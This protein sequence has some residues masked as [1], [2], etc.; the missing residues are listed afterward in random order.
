M[1]WNLLRSPNVPSLY[2][3]LDATPQRLLRLAEI[4]GW[5]PLTPPDGLP[6][7]MTFQAIAWD[8]RDIRGGELFVALRGEKV[9][10]HSYLQQAWEQGARAALVEERQHGCGI[11]QLL[12][13]DTRRALSVLSDRAWGQPSLH[14]ACIAITGTKG[15]TST[16]YFLQ[17]LLEQGDHRAAVLGTL[18]WSF[19][20]Q[21]T[22]LPL[23]TPE[24]PHLQHRF[25]AT[26]Q[27]GGTHAIFEASAHGIHFQRTRDIRLA[28]ALFTNLGHDHLDFFP[29]FEAYGATKDRLFTEQLIESPEGL[30]VLNTDDPHIAALAQVLPAWRV[31]ACGAQVPEG[32]QGR[33]LEVRR[34]GLLLQIGFP[35]G[36]GFDVVVPLAGRFFATN[37]LLA[38]ATAWSCGVPAP[39]IAQGLATMPP[40]PGRH[41]AVSTS[42]D[43]CQVIVDYAHTPESVSAIL[44]AAGRD[45]ERPLTVVIGCGGDRD[46][47]KRPQMG[48]LALDGADRVVI[49][50]DNPRSEDPLAII[51]Q[52]LEGIPEGAAN[53]LVTV[54]PDR[55]VAIARAIA[56]A[57][58]HGRVYILGKGHETYQ[59]FRDGKIDFDDCQHA[60]RALDARLAA[61]TEAVS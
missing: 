40:V 6:S 21:T 60:R 15:K 31:L 59:I 50:S 45:P 11:P 46:P 43:D 19:G 13:P 37:L 3:T 16:S 1:E 35:D 54:E 24:A 48:R 20:G 27:A 58:E 39:T 4:T 23:T 47:L 42:A 8:S 44:T 38:A 34:D 36:S 26:L 29:S 30:A 41:Q 2:Q 33:L 61:R 32:V 53:P 12:T 9:D 22:P 52:I 49:T 28:R 25:A 5:L 57:P 14:L 56:E 18:G 55:A 10:G 7:D 17:H 51:A